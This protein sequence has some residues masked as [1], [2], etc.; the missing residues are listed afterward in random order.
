VPLGTRLADPQ[1]GCRKP[2]SS[3]SRLCSVQSR[4]P[5]VRELAS[6]P[7]APLIGIDAPP[8][9]LLAVNSTYSSSFAHG[10]F[11]KPSRTV[12]ARHPKTLAPPPARWRREA[13][14]FRLR[15]DRPARAF[16]P[17][18]TREPKERSAY[19]MPHARLLRIPY[20]RFRQPRRATGVPEPKEAHRSPS[21]TVLQPRAPKGCDRITESSVERGLDRRSRWRRPSS[22]AAPKGSRADV[23]GPTR[24]SPS[25]RLPHQPALSSEHPEGH[26]LSGAN[27]LIL[28][29]ISQ[30]RRP[31]GHEQRL[32]RDEPAARSRSRPLPKG[33]GWN[34]SGSPSPQPRFRCRNRDRDESFDLEFTGLNQ[35]PPSQTWIRRPLPEKSGSQSQPEH[36]LTPRPPS[37]PP[38]G[39]SN[40]N[41]TAESARSVRTRRHS[42]A[43]GPSTPKDRDAWSSEEPA[44]PALGSR[45][46]S[47]SWTCRRPGPEGSWRFE[48][49]RAVEPS[50]R[51]I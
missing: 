37:P 42:E 44:S 4:V 7:V 24:R 48:L 29:R 3:T 1:A 50:A 15:S 43:F 46:P 33:S 27:R 35:Q 40:R 41:R 39:D 5:S 25:A 11:R 16:E 8:G 22:S 17:S 36:D 28:V 32:A 12:Q 38:E 26:L 9:A 47:S 30:T 45:K 23:A 31:T 19:G 49:R 14:S 34:R 21:E 6:P 13:R 20:P 51:R 18:A 10:V 2:S